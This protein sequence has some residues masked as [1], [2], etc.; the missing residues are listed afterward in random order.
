MRAFTLL[1]V[2][3][4]LSI[5]T[6]VVL[7]P[8]TSAINSSSYSSQSKDLMVS[9][10]LA[11]EA[12]EL[13]HYQYDTLYIACTQ[14]RD[15]CDVPTNPNEKSGAKAWRLFKERLADTT[16]GSAS[17]FDE[18]GC[19]YDFLDMMNATSSVN[20][21]KKYDPEDP[22]KCPKLSMVQSAPHG[23]LFGT[24]TSVRNYYVCSSIDQE[25]IDNRLKDNHFNVSRTN[26]SRSVFVESKPTF[27]ESAPPFYQDDLIVTATVSFRRTNGMIRA[28]RVTDFFHA[29]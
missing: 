1:E 27:T 23:E 4:S 6:L 7:G 16:D 22:D 24:N 19:A 29:R 26:Y 11:E 10:Y 3:A 25:D 21:P 9:L 12:L 28:I 20:L 8:L 13:L 2:L 5:V 17:C 15:A 14:N 18:G